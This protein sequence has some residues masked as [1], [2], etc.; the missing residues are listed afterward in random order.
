MESFQ[1]SRSSSPLSSPPPSLGDDYFD[2]LRHVPSSPLS[3]I[4]RTP[5]PPPGW[6]A[7]TPPPSQNAG[8][9]MPRPRKRRKIDRPDRTTRYLDLTEDTAQSH[10]DRTDSI[11]ELQR[12]LRNRR[13]IVV[14]AGAGISVS[15]GIPDFRSSNGLFASLKGEHKLKGGS[16]KQLFDAAVYKDADSTSQFHEMVRKLS[17][18]SQCAKPTNFHHMLARLATEG[19]LLRLY[20]QNVDGLETQMPPLGTEVPLPHKG[21][22]PQTVQLHG[23]LEKMMCQKCREIMDFDAQLF[24][25]SETPA[26]P[27]CRETDDFRTNDLGR[28]SH[29]IGRLRPRIVLYNEANPDDEA[30]GA[31]SAA[32]MRTRP[33]AIVVV[34]TSMK[35]PGVRRIVSEMCKIVRGRRDGTTVWINPDPEPTGPQF[36][37]C[38]DLIV[39]GDSDQVASLVNLRKWDDPIEEH[40]EAPTEYTDSDL[41]KVIARQ[42]EVKVNVPPS[43][44]KKSNK[45]AGVA[46]ITPPHSQSG[47]SQHQNQTKSSLNSPVRI[48][49][50]VGAKSESAEKEQKNRLLQAEAPKSLKN[51]ASSGRKLKDVLGKDGSAH[52]KA[53]KRPYRRKNVPKS[54]VAP[55]G[56]TQ[57]RIEGKATKPR[58]TVEVLVPARKPT[59]SPRKETL[60]RTFEPTTETSTVNPTATFTWTDN[61]EQRGTF[62]AFNPIPHHPN[63]H[64]HISHGNL[65][66]RQP[67]GSYYGP[68]MHIFSANKPAHPMSNVA[69]SS[70]GSTPTLIS[71]STSPH[72]SPSPQ[73]PPATS[74]GAHYGSPQ[75]SPTMHN[76][77]DTISPKGNVP[78]DMMRLLN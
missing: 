43:P 60:Q 29:G 27:R 16:G 39:K 22:W 55:D 25:G 45:S 36:E 13:K 33:D 10:F 37:D 52:N 23:G 5:S 2:D 75:G 14:I 69:P 42:G 76:R 50:V 3:S 78:K 24:A 40:P 46:V 48:K 61:L 11:K 77:Q 68:A 59:E 32:D 56:Q 31:V 44:L 57:S 66:N 73:T 8:E 51:P 67:L 64:Q 72:D 9:E 62:Q 30:I 47:E 28:R 15:A 70:Y 19:R 26:C 58:T 49:L 6:A 18:M 34:G 53:A 7:V 4:A 35:I 21:P 20:T 1:R 65:V 63:L 38:W 74:Y 54:K 12:A 41:E 17:N 71:G